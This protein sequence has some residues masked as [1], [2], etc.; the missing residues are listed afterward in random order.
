MSDWALLLFFLL[1]MLFALFLDA[2][3][4]LYVASNPH[5]G[6]EELPTDCVPRD[7]VDDS[8]IGI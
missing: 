6:E 8:E 1:G 2:L 3:G 5:A 7:E 4:D